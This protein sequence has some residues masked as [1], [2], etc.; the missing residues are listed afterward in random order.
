MLHDIIVYYIILYYMILYHII[1][2]STV[3][4]SEDAP[5]DPPF[6][7]GGDAPS[8]APSHIVYEISMYMTSH[9]PVK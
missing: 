9:I 8:P 3:Y 4:Y 6:R 2:C 7:G 1:L 5:L